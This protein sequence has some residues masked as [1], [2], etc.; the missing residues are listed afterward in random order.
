V[1]TWEL[2]PP[3]YIASLTLPP[4]LLTRVS[5]YPPAFIARHPL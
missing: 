4:T 2:R 3:P 1:F 5:Q